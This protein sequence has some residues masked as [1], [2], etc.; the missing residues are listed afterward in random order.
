MP[1][2]RTFCGSCG[3]ETEMYVQH[4]V[5]SLPKV[6]TFCGTKFG[7]DDV[8]VEDLGEGEYDEWEKLVDDAISDNEEWKWD[9]IS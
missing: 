5:D 8:S 6:C 1:A 4:D 3:A 2:F 9:L 7:I